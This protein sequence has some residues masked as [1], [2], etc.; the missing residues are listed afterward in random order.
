MA[1]LLRFGV[2]AVAA[3]ALAAGAAAVQPYAQVTPYQVFKP[4]F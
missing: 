1:A 4:L 3:V 2:G